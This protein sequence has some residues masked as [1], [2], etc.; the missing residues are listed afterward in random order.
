M[1]KFKKKAKKKTNPKQELEQVKLTSKTLS[2][3]KN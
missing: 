3:R 2:L 1:A